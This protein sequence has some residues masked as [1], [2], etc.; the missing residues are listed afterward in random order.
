MNLTRYKQKILEQKKHFL[1][2]LITAVIL[3][4]LNLSV[5]I[6]C[7]TIEM[8]LLETT[9]FFI[10]T[11]YASYMANFLVDKPSL[12]KEEVEEEQEDE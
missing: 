7:Y 11:T 1:T 10:F 5:A 3:T 12:K 8:V 6:E 2:G 9:R 4:M